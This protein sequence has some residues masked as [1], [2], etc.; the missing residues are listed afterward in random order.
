MARCP[1][2]C[3]RDFLVARGGVGLLA[4][5][6]AVDGAQGGQELE[7]PL[8]ATESYY[9][10]VTN[11][12]R[13]LISFSGCFTISSSMGEGLWGHRLRWQTPR[14]AAAAWGC[15]DF[16][17]ACRAAPAFSGPKVAGPYHVSVSSVE[18]TSQL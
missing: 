4:A 11:W 17:P 6:R 15:R 18:T 1:P 14:A 5:G 16:G 8:A 12:I 9:V 13:I 10:F 7:V 3:C 2:R